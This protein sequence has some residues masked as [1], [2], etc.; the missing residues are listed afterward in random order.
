M[1]SCICPCAKA[2]RARCRRRS[3]PASRSWPTIAMVR[4]EVCLEDKTGFLVPPGD[5]KNLTEQIAPAR[6]RC[7]VAR[8]T[9]ASAAQEFVR[10]NFAVEKM[11]DDHLR[12]LPETGRRKAGVQASACPARESRL[13]PELQPMTFPF[14]FFARRLCGRVFDDAVRAAT[15]AQ[16]V[17]AHRSR[18]RS[19]PSQN[20]RSPVPLAGGFAVLTGILLPLGV[21]A[22]PAQTRHRQISAAGL[23]VHGIDRRAIELAV[24]ALARSPSSFSAGWT[25]STN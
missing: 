7:R 13:K 6:K 3:P 9:W 2:C 23:I 5:L 22:H 15:L 16:M 14:N 11:V 1:R 10:E 12:S 25:T 20:S 24:L 18:G 21:G 19:R 8:K 17:P 4:G